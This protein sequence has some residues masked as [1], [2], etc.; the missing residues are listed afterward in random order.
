MA[1]DFGHNLLL[2]GNKMSTFS[3]VLVAMKPLAFHILVI[4]L[5][6]VRKQI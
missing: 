3:P 1:D 4:D 5:F 6:L 2:P